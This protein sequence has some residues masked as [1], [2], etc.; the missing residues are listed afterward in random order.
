[1]GF[2]TLVTIF[3]L[4]LT[5]DPG[6]GGGGGSD[7]GGGGGGGSD[8]GG[9]GGGG[10]D[11]GGGGTKPGGDGSVDSVIQFL[12]DKGVHM[13][14]SDECSRTTTQRGIFN[15]KLKSNG[16][17]INC[18]NISSCTALLP[19]GSNTIQFPEW[20]VNKQILSSGKPLSFKQVYQHVNNPPHPSDIQR[21]KMMSMTSSR[22]SDPCTR[23]I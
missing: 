15:N 10:S 20:V 17:Y 16:I 5:S 2:A 6:G 23:Y 12:K 4:E 7:P 22:E 18:G 11:P 19:S 9:G 8:P 21:S 13:L 1:V 3:I 14:G